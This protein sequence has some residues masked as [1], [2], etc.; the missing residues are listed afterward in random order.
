M[1]G[2]QSPTVS[3]GSGVDD[4]D[5]SG[6]PGRNGGVDGV[7]RDTAGLVMR[8]TRWSASWSGAEDLLELHRVEAAFECSWCGRL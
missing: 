5:G 1:F 6:G 8:L 4:G 3:C 7:C 2:F